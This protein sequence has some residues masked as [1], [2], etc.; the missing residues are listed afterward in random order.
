MLQGE[1]NKDYGERNLCELCTRDSDTKQVLLICFKSAGTLVEFAES[2]YIL[3]HKHGSDI[4][5]TAWNKS[6]LSAVRNNPDLVVN[7]IYP[8]VWQPC[9]KELKQLLMSLSELSMRL[10]DVD[11]N[12]NHHKDN[13][14]T[15][16][17]ALFRGII[18]CT[19][20]PFDLRLIERAIERIR[21]YWELC[22]YRRGAQ[23]FLKIRESL[24]LEGG[25]F[26]LVEKLS[27]E[28]YCYQS[29]RI[30]YQSF[31]LL[32]LQMSTSGDSQ[33]LHDVDDNL[34]CAGEFLEDIA[35]EPRKVECL[36]TFA[37]CKDIVKWLKDE[38]K[39]KLH[40]H[41]KIIYSHNSLYIL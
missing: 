23:I 30:F 17:A 14:D 15:Q 6:M 39:G 33:T 5:A 38:T 7:D 34:I 22:R 31:L 40:K 35:K 3:S 19:S 8:L 37:R 20:E 12:F 9:L 13:L 21:Q 36:D 41:Y 4:F 10:D 26:G 11:K 16:L 25:D 29:N 32:L 24:E 27:K 18:E 1:L 2:F 28:V